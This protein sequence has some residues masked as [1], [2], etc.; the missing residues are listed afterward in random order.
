MGMGRAWAGRGYIFVQVRCPPY[1]SSLWPPEW[2]SGAALPLLL[3]DLRFN[4][5]WVDGGYTKG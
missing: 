1:S 2:R 5:P 3:E 4:L